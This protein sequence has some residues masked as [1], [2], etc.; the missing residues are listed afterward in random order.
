ME[1]RHGQDD[2]VV[3]LHGIARTSRSMRPIEGFLGAAGYRTINLDYP[4][5]HHDLGALAAM[6]GRQ[7]AAAG[8]GDVSRLHFVTHS[9]GGLVVRHVL[10]NEQSL[11]ARVGRVVMLAPPSAGSEVADVLAPLAPYGW[12]FGPAGRQLT[13]GRCGDTPPIGPGLELGIVAGST[14]WP[15]LLGTLLLPRPHDGRVSVE[16]TRLDGMGDHLVVPAT[17]SFIMRVPEVQ[18][19]VLHFIRHGHFV[20]PGEQSGGPSQGQH[21]EA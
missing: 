13:T 19:Q 7:L 12:L 21:L 15:Y 5:R 18:R 6:V 3:L 20:R 11:R 17:H 16:R 14:G 8:A 9:M 2:L 4:S 10:A 1:H